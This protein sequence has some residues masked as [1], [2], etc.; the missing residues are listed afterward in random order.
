MG[1]VDCIVEMREEQFTAGLMHVA[2]KLLSKG[3]SIED[4]CEDTELPI[5]KVKKL[6][7]EINA[8]KK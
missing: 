6:Y 8:S 2:R 1:K 3:F 4:V 5:D 7:D